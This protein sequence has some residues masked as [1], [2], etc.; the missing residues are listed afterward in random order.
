[1]NTI[2]PAE[3]ARRLRA[4]ADLLCHAEAA[5]LAVHLNIDVSRYPSTF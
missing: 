4:V 2:T 5:P 1:M 3:T